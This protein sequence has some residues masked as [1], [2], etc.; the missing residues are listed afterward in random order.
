MVTGAALTLGGAGLARNVKRLNTARRLTRAVGR[1][2]PLASARRGDMTRTF[3]RLQASK[4]S[5]GRKLLNK[6]LVTGSQGFH[7][8][9][10]RGLDK[11]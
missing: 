11:L 6:V 7:A 5:S 9:Q 8:L 4:L 1:A 10:Q 3:S 2:R